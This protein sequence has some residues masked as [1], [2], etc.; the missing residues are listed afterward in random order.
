MSK[1][2][3]TPEAIL[4]LLDRNNLAVERAILALFKRQT[5][6]EQATQATSASNGRGFSSFDAPKGTYYANWIKSGRHLTGKHLQHAR[7]MAKKYIRQLVEEAEL[8]H[9]RLQETQN[10]DDVEREA[11]VEHS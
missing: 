7:M 3:A 2:P 9:R 10:T 1:V 4:D 6:E 11:I 8:T 5:P